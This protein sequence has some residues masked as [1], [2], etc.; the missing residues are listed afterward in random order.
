M[1]LTLGINLQILTQIPPLFPLIS[2][3][4]VPGSSTG[5]RI[6]RSCGASF[7]VFPSLVCP[8]LSW[9][10]HFWFLHWSFC[11]ISLSWV[12][13]GCCLRIRWNVC[14]FWQENHRS[15]VVSF[16]LHHMMRRMMSL[17]PWLVT[18]FLDSW[19]RWCLS[20][21]FVKL[22]LA[23]ADILF[24]LKHPPTDFS[25]HSPVWPPA[26]VPVL[27]ASWCLVFPS[28]IPHL[29]IWIVLSGRTALLHHLFIYSFMLVWA[30]AYVF[31]SMG[32]NPVLR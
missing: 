17:C 9:P 20:G 24:L 1:T 3:F 31:Y 27:S 15:D 7:N 6:A 32:H 8:C 23:S 13:A 19:L 4:F 28:F 29:S 30:H 22:L 18:W 10:W 26:A 14:I 21:F 11:G 5:A 25:I 16:S 2:Y 12:L